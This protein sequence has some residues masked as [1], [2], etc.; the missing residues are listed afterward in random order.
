MQIEIKF[1]SIILSL[2]FFFVFFRLVHRRFI[3]PFFLI[4]W[5][6]IGLAMLSVW[7]FHDFYVWIAKLLGITDATYLFFI[8]AI[9]FLMVYCLYLT[10]QISLASDRIQELISYSA[11]LDHKIRTLQTCGR[12]HIPGE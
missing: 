3:N 2:L 11:Y 7:P 8:G 5:S 6:G 9:L 1:I 10:V 4:L 12:K